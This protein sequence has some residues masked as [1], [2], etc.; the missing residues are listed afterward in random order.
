MGRIFQAASL[1]GVT[2][3]VR[4]VFLC[5]QTSSINL[6]A[7]CVNVQYLCTVHLFIFNIKPQTLNLQTSY[8]PVNCNILIPQTFPAL[9]YAILTQ[10]VHLLQFQQNHLVRL[11]L[12]LPLLLEHLLL[13]L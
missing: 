5:S 3:S 8:F 4:V 9:R 2:S 6:V 7:Q 12:T 10:Q 13:W 1:A 11:A